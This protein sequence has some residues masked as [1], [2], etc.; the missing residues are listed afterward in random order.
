MKFPNYH[1]SFYNDLLELEHSSVSKYND[2]I[3]KVYQ[4]QI[5]PQITT[6]SL[7]DLSFESFIYALDH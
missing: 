4:N 7:V 6:Y 2:M 5:M 1:S 3:F